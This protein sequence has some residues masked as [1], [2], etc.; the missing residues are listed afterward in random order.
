[1]PL[2]VFPCLPSSSQQYPYQESYAPDHVPPLP[3]YLS[4]S[5]YQGIGNETF[6]ILEIQL[7]RQTSGFGFKIIG[8]AEEGTQVKLIILNSKDSFIWVLDHHMKLEMQQ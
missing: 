4:T 5:Y 1:M 7:I 8:G 3:W 2:Y 6:S